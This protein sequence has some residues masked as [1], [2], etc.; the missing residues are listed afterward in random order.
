MNDQH[1]EPENSSDLSHNSIHPLLETSSFNENTTSN[2]SVSSFNHTVLRPPNSNKQVSRSTQGAVIRRQLSL[3]E[4]S[5][6]RGRSRSRITSPP[7]TRRRAR[8]ESE[9]R[10]YSSQKSE[11]QSGA[12]AVTEL[13]DQLADALKKVSVRAHQKLP[14]PQI[15]TLK[16]GKSFK[17]FIKHFERYCSSV[18]SDNPDDWQDLLGKYL[19]GEIKEMYLNIRKGEKTY[20]GLKENLTE[21]YQVRKKY[22][23]VNYKT[24]FKEA[25]ME[26]GES[27]WGY[28][29]RLQALAKRAY[30]T[31]YEKALKKKFIKT[32]PESFTNIITMYSFAKHGSAGTSIRDLEWK[33][34]KELASLQKQKKEEFLPKKTS[35]KTQVR[36]SDD[37]SSEDSDEEIF[38]YV[39]AAA[40]TQQ[41]K[42]TGI[43][44]DDSRGN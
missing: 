26:A 11:G 25:K 13:V 7:H 20:A 21:W 40:L 32:A 2:S 31:K 35:Y 37:S 24:E 22:V 27:V 18:I 39:G 15:F 43:Q 44:T 14:A 10:R 5:L 4:S 6:E 30:G 8:N 17:E 12:H 28:A 1:S 19:K 36:N 33:S 16:E 34:I 29:V 9:K 41:T 23:V 38:K 42:D 3:N